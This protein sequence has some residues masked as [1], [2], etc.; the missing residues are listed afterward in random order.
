MSVKPR[1]QSDTHTIGFFVRL[2]FIQTVVCS[3]KFWRKKNS[4]KAMSSE[5][6]GGI[7]MVVNSV[8]FGRLTKLSNST[9]NRKQ[10]ETVHNDI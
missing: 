5:F 8:Y 9:T 10:I 1:Q 2:S 6:V 3:D 4:K 7:F